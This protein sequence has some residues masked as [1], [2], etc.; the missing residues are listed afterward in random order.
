MENLD[1]M[2]QL[3][4]DRPDAAH[5]WRK[6]FNPDLPYRP[7]RWSD[8]AVVIVS[9]G[10]LGAVEKDDDLDKKDKRVIPNPSFRDYLKVRGGGLGAHMAW[11]SG[12][13]HLT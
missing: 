13:R 9:D 3:S 1:N 12:V 4:K 11:S 6:F 10:I 7:L 2:I 5:G 8:F